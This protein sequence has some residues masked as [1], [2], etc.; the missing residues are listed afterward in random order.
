MFHC[1]HVE[2]VV[3]LSIMNVRSYT[4]ENVSYILQLRRIRIEAQNKDS[5]AFL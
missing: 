2:G 3:V 4:F 5:V 1:C